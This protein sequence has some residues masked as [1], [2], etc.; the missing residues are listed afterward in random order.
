[1]T[2]TII[3]SLFT[4]ARLLVF[5]LLGALLL[6]ACKPSQEASQR[7]PRRQDVTF[8]A[9]DL[10][11]SSPAIQT[12]QLY[13]NGDETS[14]PIYSLGGSNPLVLE[15]DLMEVAGRPLQIQFEH[16]N[17][18]WEEDFLLPSQFLAGLQDDLLVDYLP[19]AGTRPAYTHYEYRFPN[20]TIEFTYSGNYILT[21]TEQGRMDEVLFE[22]PFVVSEQRAL[23]NVG[24][25]QVLADGSG[26][27][28][29]R[30]EAR[31]EP[32]QALSANI[33]D[34]NACFLR[35][36]RFESA[37]C[38]DSPRLDAFPFLF[39][40][41]ERFSSFEPTREYH[42]LDLSELKVGLQIETI[43]FATEP[44]EVR[45]VE[46]AAGLGGVL[47]NLAQFEQPVV[48]GAVRAV[49]NPDI[50]SEYASVLFSYLPPNE[51]PL[52]EE[53]F[54]AGSFNDWRPDESARLALNEE[55]GR[56]EGRL[57]IKQGIYEYQYVS[58]GPQPRTQGVF[59]PPTLYT[60]LAYYFDTL[61]G[62]DRLLSVNSAVGR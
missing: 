60:A 21:V 24:V 57:L 3:S 56:Y 47:D 31:F 35:N 33:Y 6:P 22:L 7:L 11:P 1:M 43:D 46:D 28:V 15:F 62:T 38:P 30:P 12:I 53:I 8:V 23:L 37:R 32:P 41:L 55:T 20:E 25:E 36:M 52:A 13:Q 26:L 9:L 17:R 49:N 5:T 19:S 34:F 14:R 29:G 10:L 51:T 54:V 45:L 59:N 4:P 40:Q 58:S 61:T 27:V 42:T 50:Q 18:Y 44:F 39:F 2:E 16:R 48:S